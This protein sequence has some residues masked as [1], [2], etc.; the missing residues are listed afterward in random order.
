MRN[1]TSTMSSATLLL[2]G[3]PVVGPLQ[4]IRRHPSPSVCKD[5]Q[6]KAD[7][8]A[9]FVTSWDEGHPW[10]LKLA[11]LL[12]RLAFPATFFVPGRNPNRS[13]QHA[14]MPVVSAS[15]LRQLASAFEV[16]A[17]TLDCCPLNEV[18]DSEAARQIVEGKGLLEDVL[19]DP[20][21]GFCYPGGRFQAKHARMVQDAGYLYARSVKDL[22]GSPDS[23]RYAVPTTMEF[24]PHPSSALFKSYLRFGEWAERAALLRAVVSQPSLGARVRAAL[25]HVC[26][27]GG[28][29]HLWGRSWQ[30][31]AFSGW[32]LL[33]DFLRYAAERIPP[34]R[35]FDNFE[36]YGLA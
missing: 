35:R 15:E 11:E 1:E 34:E 26:D 7:S 8:D 23:N 27:R 22:C 10:D 16:G 6:T 20:V 24:Y 18:P 3:T 36:A 31:E 12:D 2:G 28:T 4:A 9:I 30:I 25:D 19:G 33:E 17:H 5:M 14:D 21:F 32:S 29:F 13:A